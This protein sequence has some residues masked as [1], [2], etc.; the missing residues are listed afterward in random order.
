MLVVGELFSKMRYQGAGSSSMNP[1]NLVTS[2]DAFDKNKVKYEY[3]LGYKE[4]TDEVNEKLEH[5]VLEKAD[6]FDK[7]IFNHAANFIIG[8]LDNFFF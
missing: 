6:N 1:Y 5:E 8:F 4:N 7:I 2:K 3:V